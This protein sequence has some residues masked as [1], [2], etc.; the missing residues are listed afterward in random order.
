MMNKRLIPLSLT[1]TICSYPRYLF[2]RLFV[3]RPC[4]VSIS[5]SASIEV[6]G[7]CLFNSEFDDKRVRKNRKS[8]RLYLGEAAT[9]RVDS[10]TFYSGTTLS[11]NKNA[12]FSMGKSYC[13]YDCR[14]ACFD[15]IKIG[16]GCA[17]S[18]NVTI[19]D[20]DNHEVVRDGYERTAPIVLEDNV[21]VG[22]NATILKGV[23]IGEGSIVAAGAVV[24]NSCPPHSLIAGVPA[25]VIKSGVHWKR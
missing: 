16:D 8:G 10:T 14:I 3:V 25:R 12:T 13:N 7:Y 11:V 15:N 20:S 18:Q 21:W 2:K 1:K 23:R 5:K 19:R 22:I 4:S 17:I 9:F 24:T 6:N